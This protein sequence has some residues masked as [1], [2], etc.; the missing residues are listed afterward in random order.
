M[1][2]MYAAI[3]LSTDPPIATV[4]FHKRDM[5]LYIHSDAST[6]S[7]PKPR[8]RMG[9]CFYLGKTTRIPLEDFHNGQEGKY[10]WQ[11]LNV[12]GRKQTYHPPE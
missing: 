3:Q 6:L 9:G 10:I 4:R 1:Y 11:I 2:T 5:P 8:S 7:Y 12:L